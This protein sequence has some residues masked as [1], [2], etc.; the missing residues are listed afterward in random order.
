MKMLI[1]LAAAAAAT[2]SGPVM[3]APV[4][5]ARIHY[6]DLDLS[7]AAGQ[8]VLAARVTAVERSLCS[9]DPQTGSRIAASNADCIKSFR[10]MTSPQ[11]EAAIAKARTRMSD[12]AGR[13]SPGSS[14]QN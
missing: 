5:D 7:T 2:V 14:A 6:D 3:A 1:A 8:Q 13:N 9:A 10:D 4:A 11:I 12:A